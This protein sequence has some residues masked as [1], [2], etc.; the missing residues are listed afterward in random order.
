MD[1]IAIPKADPSAAV[2]FCVVDGPQSKGA[3]PISSQSA[4]HLASQEPTRGPTTHSGAPGLRPPDVRAAVWPVGDSGGHNATSG[5]SNCRSL[6]Q[7]LRHDQTAPPP[8]GDHFRR[9]GSA[10]IL[11]RS[12]AT[13]SPRARHTDPF[14]DPSTT[15]PEFLRLPQPR[16]L[17]P[18]LVRRRPMISF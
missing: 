4:S 17:F 9:R 12:F 10:S 11:R 6:V 3:Q 14:G 15:S 2:G 18:A 1:N 16:S 5:T 13:R 8:F 7:P